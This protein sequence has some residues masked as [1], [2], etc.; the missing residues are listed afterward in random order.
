MSW[1]FETDAEF[2]AQLDWIDEFVRTCVEPLDHVLDCAYDVKNP[3][4]IRLM[5]PLQQEVKARGLW[6]CHLGPELG[7]QGFGQV[8]LG[9]MNEILGRSDFAPVVFGCQAPDSGNAEILA[10]FGTAEQKKRWLEPLLAGEIVSCF[11]MTEPQGGADPQVFTTTAVRDGNEWVINGEKWFS[12]NASFA[13]FFIVMAVTNPDAP[14][15]S[16][17]SMFIVPAGTPGLEIIRDVGFASEKV[18]THGYLRYTNVRVPADHILGGEGQA[19]VVAQTRLGGGRIHHAMRT[20]GE[21]KAILD[22]TCERVL[23]RVTKGERLAKKQLVQ[24]KIADSWIELEQFRLLV[25]RTAW[26]IDKHQD[27]KRVRKDIAAVKALMPRVL[28]DIA[29]RALHLHG[30]IGVSNEMPFAHSVINSFFLGLADG[31]TEVHKVT[32]AR[33]VLAGYQ[34]TTDL[35]PSYHLPRQR[36]RA[37]G[38]YGDSLEDLQAVL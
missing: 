21:C 33:E 19:F 3:A 18:A 8:K 22:M 7:G 4:N 24:E 17:Q 1:S 16:A 32:V 28:H 15:I 29:A 34:P 35:F 30:S 9:L 14:L 5:R 20:I 38:L 27:Y 6:A 36:E 31:P 26:L 23:S 12:S 25:L 10:H 11:S 2:Q 37:L 13:D